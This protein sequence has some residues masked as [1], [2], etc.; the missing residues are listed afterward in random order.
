MNKL[1]KDSAVPNPNSS[2][3]KPDQTPNTSGSSDNRFGLGNVLFQTTDPTDPADDIE[4]TAAERLEDD[5]SA[6]DTFPNKLKRVWGKT[7]VSLEKTVDLS[8]RTY[9]R[10]QPWIAKTWYHITPQAAHP[11]RWKWGLLAA[12][13]GVIFGGWFWF[14]STLPSTQKV[15]TFSR[16][17]TIT[18][19]AI[20]GEIL[21]QIGDATRRKINL[22]K[23]PKFIGNAFVAAEDR[24]FYQ[25]QG[26]DVQGILRAT[27]S[28]VRSMGVVEGAST[29][30]QQVARIVYLS[31]E[32]SALRKVRELAIAH[33]IDHEL[34]KEQILEQYLNLVYLG[35]GAYGVADAAWV[36]F[37]KEIDQLTLPEVALIAGLAPAPSEY[38][39][40]V[41][42]KYALERRNLVLE[43]MQEMGTLSAAEVK[44]A[45]ATPLRLNP[46]HPQRLQKEAPYFTSY[47]LKELPNYIPKSV[48]E[49]GGLTI[50]TTLNSKWQKYAERA[51]TET[52]R[53]DG[54][55]QAFEQAALVAIDPQ[56]GGIRAMVGGYDFNKSQFNRVT[57]AQRQPGSTFK[58]FVYATA[59]AT[60]MS[61]HQGYLDA[62]IRVDGYSP[63]N[64]HHT[65]S[66]WLSVAD[67][68][69][70]SVNII[71]VKT[72][73]DVG[74]QPVIK[75]SH[76]M[77][78]QSKLKP[79]YSLALGTS[80]VNLLELTSAYGTLAAEGKRTKP[81]GIVEIRGREGQLL[82]TAKP[83]QKRAIDQDSAA[84]T[85]WLLE[86]VVQNGTG[87]SAN[88]GRP[89]AGKTGTSEEARDLLFVGYI[90]QLV[91]G[92]WL[93]NDNND[94]TGGASST[95]AYTWGQFMR[96]AAQ[97][98]T[99]Q[100]FPDLPKKIE[101]RKGSIKAQPV[102][103]KRYEDLPIPQPSPDPNS[104][105]SYNPNQQQSGGGYSSGGYYDSGN[106]SGGYHDS[107]RSNSSSNYYD[108]GGGGGGYSNQGHG[109]YRDPAPEPP[110]E[111]APEPEPAPEPAPEPS[112]NTGTAY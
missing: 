30:T 112:A 77:G 100:L 87:Q 2:E 69:T 59:M 88:I 8:Q 109:S 105:Q 68:I 60:G 57:Q 45:K 96:F 7:Q 55:G 24:R 14:D 73:I 43:R 84:I 5:D 71:A 98:M 75:M 20:D 106:P 79:T 93:G 107:G 16:S 27:F 29:I 101:G 11:N 9:H 61:P 66:G 76:E 21:Q 41:H 23:A 72:L 15:L 44:A 18:I 103:P 63:E 86:G 95:A 74:F 70:N 17:G 82:Y 54:P 80:E 89:V 83:Q 36:Y 90:P 104:Q 19:K 42:P 97:D 28:N 22:K 12:T 56:T 64:S 110:P 94:P 38:S 65:F 91:A 46:K 58:A 52:V 53:Y 108:Q 49:A 81:Y 47:I 1:P 31:Q 32:R 102:K 6:P 37:G 10:A 26:V 62:P 35:S 85:T 4:N 13:S 48:I 3:R 25:H 39:P 67:A 51:V 78:I 33:K 99:V 40:L 111:S 50:Q 92:V 34:S